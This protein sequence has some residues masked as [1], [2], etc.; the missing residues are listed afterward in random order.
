MRGRVDVRLGGESEEE[1]GPERTIHNTQHSQICVKA[2]FLLAAAAH[3]EISPPLLTARHNQEE[4]TASLSFVTA[5]QQ[6][7]SQRNSRTSQVLLLGSGCI[8]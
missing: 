1:A 6:G 7:M 2:K 3:F 5:T 8:R 4:L